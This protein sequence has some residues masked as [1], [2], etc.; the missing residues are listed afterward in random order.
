MIRTMPRR[1]VIAALVGALFS[2]VKAAPAFAAPEVT[3]WWVDPESCPALTVPMARQISLACEA[4][5]RSCE[6]VPQA[7][8][9]SRRI[10]LHCDSSEHW[11][12]EAHDA[13]GAGL[14][15][16]EV[17]GTDDDRIRQASLWVAREGTVEVFRP[18]ST[19]NAPS[20]PPPVEK[21]A[22]SAPPE[23]RG[24]LAMAGR[25]IYQPTPQRISDTLYSAGLGL[26]FIDSGEV[27]SGLPRSVQGYLSLAGESTI[28]TPLM[29]V[30]ALRVGLGA[31][32]H[33]P[34][35]HDVLNLT[36]EAG[37]G[38]SRATL[39][40]PEHLVLNRALA[41]AQGGLMIQLP[42]SGNLKPF[43]ALTIGATGPDA[44]AGTAMGMGEIGCTWNAW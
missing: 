26:R 20:A 17:R 29:R 14:W 44:F 40:L 21:P 38:Y 11:T 3:S 12:L 8:T 42:V 5:G 24:G 9:A 10:S 31:I 35:S 39:E 19:P 6:V 16:I 13:S 22:P 23:K 41:Y 15:H 37:V 43:A 28:A 18:P 27:L 30:L 25:F 33:V 1:A 36:A 32:W 7:T 4:A 2:L 34:G